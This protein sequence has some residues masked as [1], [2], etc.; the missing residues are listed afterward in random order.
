[1][2]GKVATGF[3]IQQAVAVRPSGRCCRASCCLSCA[4][5]SLLSIFNTYNLRIRGGILPPPRKAL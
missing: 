4:V 3:T 5:S 1:M 2:K